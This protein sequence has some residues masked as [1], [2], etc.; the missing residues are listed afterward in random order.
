M[1]H[2]DKSNRSAEITLISYVYVFTTNNQINYVN[3]TYSLE[4]M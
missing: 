3:C 1:F 4:E 2:F